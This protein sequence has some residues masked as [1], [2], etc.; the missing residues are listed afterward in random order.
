MHDGR[1]VEAA[2][3][4]ARVGVGKLLRQLHRH[5]ASAAARDERS[6]GL[7]AAAQP[8]PQPAAEDKVGDLG[9]RAEGGAE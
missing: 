7:G 5:V 2:V 3:R 9:E 6:E 4:R 8:P 1:A